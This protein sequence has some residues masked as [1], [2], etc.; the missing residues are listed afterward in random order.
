MQDKLTNENPED[1]K[2]KQLTRPANI[3]F[4]RLAVRAG[5]MSKQKYIINGTTYTLGNGETINITSNKALNTIEIKSLTAND[6]QYFTVKD[7]EQITIEYA[8]CVFN[9]VTRN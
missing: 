4:T 1:V 3:T 5:W 9:N 2:D 7:G 6:F 8:L